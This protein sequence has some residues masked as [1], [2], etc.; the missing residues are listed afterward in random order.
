[1]NETAGSI[2]GADPDNRLSNKAKRHMQDHKATPEEQRLAEALKTVSRYYIIGF[3]TLLRASPLTSSWRKSKVRLSGRKISSTPS[4]RQRGTLVHFWMHLA[5]RRVSLLLL[6]MPRL[7]VS[8]SL[9]TF[10]TNRRRRSVTVD[11][12]TEFARQIG[13]LTFI[14]GCLTF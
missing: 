7:T 14:F 4:Q 12:R 13:E 6:R 2:K 8:M 5:V 11:R 3:Y 10:D 1:L 9:R